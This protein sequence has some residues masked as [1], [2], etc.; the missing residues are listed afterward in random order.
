MKLSEFINMAVTRFINNTAGNPLFDLIFT[1]FFL[2][3][4]LLLSK[5]WALC[6]LR[7]IFI[8]VDFINPI[9]DKGHRE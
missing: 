2:W 4:L 8:V 7:I 3:G 1:F 5:F 9:K 6:F